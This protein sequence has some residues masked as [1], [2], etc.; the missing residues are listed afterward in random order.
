MLELLAHKRD[1]VG[2]RGGRHAVPVEIG[3]D[4]Q[5]AEFGRPG[6]YKFAIHPRAFGVEHSHADRFGPLLS[7]KER[8]QELRQVSVGHRKPTQAAQ[9]LLSVLIKH[10]AGHSV[11]PPWLWKRMC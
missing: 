7:G 5:L 9:T 11:D 2:C 6:P 3:L 8:V 1:Q 10:P 4:R